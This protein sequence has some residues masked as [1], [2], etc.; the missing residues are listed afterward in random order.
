LLC[1]GRACHR[2]LVL[3]RSILAA[4]LA[5]GLLATPSF[6]ATG[7]H[8]RG[9]NAQAAMIA[10]TAGSSKQRVQV[11][12]QLCENPNTQHRCV[13]LKRSVQRALE[14]AISAPI[15]WVGHQQ[16]HAGQFWVLGTVRFNGSTATTIVSWRDPGPYGCFGWTSLGWERRHG[17]WTTSSGIATEGC[18]AGA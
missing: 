4:T 17:G 10:E 7:I 16:P 1:V 8:G 13:S 15:T 3:K 12:N 9:A 18:P 11:L 14:D 6:A 2:S 5:V